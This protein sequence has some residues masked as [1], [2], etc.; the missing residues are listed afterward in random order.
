MITLLH[1]IT[2]INA[3]ST[4]TNSVSGLI[5]GGT[6]VL[7]GASR[8]PGGAANGGLLGVGGILGLVSTVGNAAITALPAVSG[9]VSGQADANVMM[10][11]F[12]AIK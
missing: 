8:N 1:L 12:G 6:A 10:E 4:L 9:L 3:A 7:S 2:G 5:D 11:L